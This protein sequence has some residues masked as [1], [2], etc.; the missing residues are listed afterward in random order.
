[1]ICQLVWW[2]EVRPDDSTIL[3]PT[4]SKPVEILNVCEDFANYNISTVINIVHMY[5]ICYCTD[6][7]RPTCY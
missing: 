4:L 3:C 1:M 5:N 7:S 2:D 6:T